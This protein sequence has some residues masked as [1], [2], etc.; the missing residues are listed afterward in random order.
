MSDVMGNALKGVVNL[1]TETIYLYDET[2][3]SVVTVIPPSGKVARVFY[4]RPRVVRM[5]I[6][7][8]KFVAVAVPDEGASHSDCVRADFEGMEGE[9][10]VLVSKEVA[11]AVW[12]TYGD[13]ASLWVADD[14]PES[15]VL[16]TRGVRMG[17]KRLLLYTSPQ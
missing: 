7:D 13:D 16:D 6:G 15:V 10:N 1:T 12:G 4:A 5:D 3:V 17:Y 9:K 11:D 14:S 2:G 8:G